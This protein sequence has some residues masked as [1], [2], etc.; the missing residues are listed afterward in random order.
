MELGIKIN[1]RYPIKQQ[2]TLEL[3]IFKLY[4][5]LV[6]KNKHYEKKKIQFHT[7]RCIGFPSFLYKHL[8]PYVCAMSCLDIP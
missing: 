5:H 2:N 7:N 4:A 6:K 1:K 8:W 3:K